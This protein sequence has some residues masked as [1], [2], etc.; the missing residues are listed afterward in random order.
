M[1]RLGMVTAISGLDPELL[2]VLESITAQRQLGFCPIFF[3]WAQQ[4][5][6]TGAFWFCEAEMHGASLKASESGEAFPH[7]P[8]P[9][10]EH[11]PRRQKDKINATRM[12]RFTGISMVLIECRKSS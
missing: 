3:T 5:L 6:D 7:S 1:H 4:L 11:K 9:F 8:A 2:A 10:T 12:N